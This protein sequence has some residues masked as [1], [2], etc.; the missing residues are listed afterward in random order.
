DELQRLRHFLKSK[1]DASVLFSIMSTT[2]QSPHICRRRVPPANIEWP[3]SFASMLSTISRVPKGLPQRT[4]LKGSASFSVT[5]CLAFSSSN[6]LGMREIA[7]SGQVF[8]HS[9]HCTQ[10]R[11]MKRS[12]GASCESISADSGQ[13]PMQALQSVHV[14]LFTVSV[15]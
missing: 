2:R 5:G 14:C 11:S 12:A 9:P 4:Q 6:N 15:P 13:A 3:P 7:C 10:F 8:A 1:I